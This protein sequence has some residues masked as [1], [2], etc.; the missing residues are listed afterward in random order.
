MVFVTWAEDQPGT[1]RRCT[2]GQPR[3]P[4]Q[5]LLQIPRIPQQHDN[6]WVWVL[7]VITAA[8]PV[9]SD[10]LLAIFSAENEGIGQA[11]DLNSLLQEKLEKSGQNVDL[12]C[13]DYKQVRAANFIRRLLPFVYQE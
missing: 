5:V 12:A 1:A 13:P 4:D 6:T 10:S 2:A 3:D 7:R 9:P 11:P 8:A